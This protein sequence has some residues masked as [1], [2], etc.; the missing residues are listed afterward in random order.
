[1]KVLYDH[2]AF[3]G[4]GYGGVSRY[5]FELMRFFANQQNIDFEL[6]LRLSNNDYLDEASFSRHVR[7]R[8]LSQSRNV[9]RVAS[10][11]NRMYSLGRIRAG[12]F[13]V[14]HP[15]YYHRYFLDSLGSKP[16][17]LT[18]HDAASERFGD[19]YPDLGAGL[20]QIKKTLIERADAIVAVSEFSKQELLHFFPIDPAKVSVVHLGTSFGL[21]P[22]AELPRLS[23]AAEPFPY[24]LYVGKRRLYK[25][26]DPFF[27]AMQIVLQQHPDLC[28]I[29]AGGGGVQQR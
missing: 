15:T 8:S 18:F 21:Q 10:A 25:N 26:F 3:T 11:L 7:Y 16:F 4:L 5:F 2:Q 23:V 27:R 20:Y 28:L 19:I 29:C 1:M 24:V 12:K 13:D 22:A 6:S 17:V 9:N 14:F